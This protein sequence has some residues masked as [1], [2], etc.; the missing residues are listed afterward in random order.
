MLFMFDLSVFMCELGFENEIKSNL[1]FIIEFYKLFNVTSSDEKKEN[2][3]NIQMNIWQ[4]F[5]S[6]LLI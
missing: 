1:Y 3:D 4:L 6:Y 2:V 5:K